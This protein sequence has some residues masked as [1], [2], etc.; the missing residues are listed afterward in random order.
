MIKS[1]NYLSLF[2]FGNFFKKVYVC[3]TNEIRCDIIIML[4]K[5]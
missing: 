3:L 2:S 5:F 4:G 1:D